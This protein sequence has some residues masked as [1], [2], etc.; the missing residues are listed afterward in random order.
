MLLSRILTVFCGMALVL[1][2]QEAGGDGGRK[3]VVVTGMTGKGTWEDPRRP[4][5]PAGAALNFRWVASD[6]GQ[7]AI[8][9]VELARVTAE[10]LKALD[11]TV[12]GRGPVVK[13]FARGSGRKEDVE[14]E[15]KRYRKDFDLDEFLGGKKVGGV[16]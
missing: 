9:E 3:L 7:W 11:E 12:A 4:V 15:L 14:K 2:A 10:G 16:K 6:D 8:V 1:G 13:V 5:L